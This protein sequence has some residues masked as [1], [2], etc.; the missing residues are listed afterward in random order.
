M[1]DMDIS[2]QMNL[3]RLIKFNDNP[4]ENIPKEIILSK[5]QLWCPYCSNKVVFKKDKKLGIKKCPICNISEKDFW[6]K[7]VNAL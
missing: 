1:T 6:V 7:K 5:K 2:E 4:D 3:F